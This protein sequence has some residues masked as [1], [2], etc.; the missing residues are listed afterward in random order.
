MTQPTENMFSRSDVSAAE[1][2]SLSLGPSSAFL[3]ASIPQG[4]SS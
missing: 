1:Y 4:S 2:A 3:S